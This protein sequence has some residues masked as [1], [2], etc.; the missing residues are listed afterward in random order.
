M[1]IRRT[2]PPAAAPV[3][4]LDLLRGAAGFLRGKTYLR[5]R[6]QEL[7][8]FFG[9]EHVFL[10][11]SGKAA[12][13]IILRAL[14]ALAPEK[15][16]VLIPA[17]TCFSVP[18]AIVKAGLAVSA[19]D[20]GPGTFDF[21]RRLLTKE[22]T[23][24]ILC[25]VSTHLFG[26][27]AETERLAGICKPR[28]IFVVEDAA[29]AMG[30]SSNGKH[31][32]T[33]GD[34]GFFSLGRGKNITCGSGGIIITGD[35]RI[36][37]AI[38]NEYRDL[39]LP[40]PVEDLK[41]MM[42]LFA[43]KV[44]MHPGLYWIPAGI[45]SLRLGETVFST[46]FPIQKLSG[47]KAGFLGRWRSRLMTANHARRGECI[48]LE[49]E[50]RQP[51]HRDSPACIRFPVLAKDPGNR[52]ELYA[53]GKVHGISLM[54]PS[55]VNEIPEIKKQFDG[56]TYPRAKDVSE[57]LVT[58]PTHPLVTKRDRSAIVRTLNP[59]TGNPPAP[60]GGGSTGDRAPDTI[61]CGLPAAGEEPVP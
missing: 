41:E 15:R 34:I 26:I 29:Q 52:E 36:A 51:P 9:V 43:M 2:V 28:G 59:A 5:R 61:P 53:R 47:M 42:R 10:V 58:L 16:T 54:Y 46:D 33:T 32:G 48:A 18:S 22:L 39:G 11:S 40:A 23:E 24:D 25:V 57:R 4:F 6:E 12:L 21:D 8:E 56:R 30:E 3:S 20:L 45:P 19:C 31:L 13:T 35:R 60:A 1:K 44:F 38:Q 27:P 14:K 55:P 37:E 49:R 17:Y 7:R 50:L